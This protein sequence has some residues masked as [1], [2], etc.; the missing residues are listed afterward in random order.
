M[1]ERE[2]QAPRLLLVECDDAV[3]NAESAALIEDGFEIVRARD[4]GEAMRAVTGGRFDL[5]LVNLDNLSQGALDFCR[6]L[7]DNPALNWMPVMF[8]TKTITKDTVEKVYAAGADEFVGWPCQ[9]QEMTIRAKALLRK[10]QEE[11]WLVDRAR[12][13]AEKIEEAIGL[14]PLPEPQ[15]DVDE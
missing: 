4:G 5:A 15:R 3:A 9:P 12:K 6:T 14:P 7:K 11:R 8:S 13:L 1:S 10:G 2:A